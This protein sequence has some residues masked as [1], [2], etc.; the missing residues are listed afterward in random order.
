MYA[1]LYQH[2]YSI[3]WK[4]KYLISLPVKLDH[5]RNAFQQQVHVTAI[6]SCALTIWITIHLYIKIYRR[7][8]TSWPSSPVFVF[9][10]ALK[11]LK[12]A[13]IFNAAFSTSGS[14]RSISTSSSSG[15]W[16]ALFVF[17]AYFYTQFDFKRKMWCLNSHTTKIP[18][19][20]LPYLIYPTC[21]L[22]KQFWL[23]T[24]LLVWYF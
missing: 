5:N 22:F 14:S 17:C 12:P 13:W 24:L 16:L 11:P 21:T 1:W 4:F 15:A 10:R 9:F 7:Q 8:N 6:L 2:W 23:L 3:L 18:P 19:T 20:N